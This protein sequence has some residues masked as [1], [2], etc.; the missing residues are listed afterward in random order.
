[1]NNEIEKYPKIAQVFKQNQINFPETLL[2]DKFQHI[3]QKIEQL[4]GSKEAINYLD[5]L[6]LEE[7]GDRQGFPIEIFN[8]ISLIK[9]VHNF[10]YPELDFSPYDPFSTVKLFIPK[11]G[12]PV[13]KEPEA[14]L[15]P[16]NKVE[17]VQARQITETA[18]AKAATEEP[19]KKSDHKSIDWPKVHTQHDLFEYAELRQK[20]NSR[21]YTQQ[22]K[23][24]GEIL[25]HYKAINENSLT[26]AKRIQQK[27]QHQNKAIGNILVE[28]GII[29]KEELTF[30]LCIQSGIIV[31]DILKLPINSE[32][33]KTIPFEI[34][35][36]TH[37]L[38]IGIFHKILYLTVDD[39]FTFNEKSFF[40]MM[41]GYRIELAYAPQ[42]EIINRLN[43][44]GLFGSPINAQ[45]EFSSM[46]KKTLYSRPKSP[47]VKAAVPEEIS[48][49]DSAIINLVN[50]MILNAVEVA[51]SDIH[52]EQFMGNEEADIRFR[53]D[54][55]MEHFAGFPRDH[56]NAV[57]SRIKIIAG[58]D[59]SEKRH[60]Q[61]GKISFAIHGGRRIDL[62]VATIPVINGVEFVT[63]RILHSGEPMRL[64][65]LGMNERDM[66]VFRE[67]FSRPY[68]LILV[69]GP[70]G[71]GKTT[72]LHSVLKELNTGDNKIWTAEDPVEIVQPHL[73]QVQVNSK[74]DLTFANV[75]RSFLRADP[76]II[77][78][79]EMRDHE[80]AKIALEASMT[81][82]LVLST[83]HTNSASEAVARL[84]DMDIDPF[85]LSD[86][87]LA[88]LAQRL[89]RKLC[90]EC[91][92]QEEI[93]ESELNDLA[94]EYHKSAYAKPAT[95]AEREAIINQWRKK[96]G[97]DGQLYS[98][99]PVGCKMCDAGYK[100]RVG[101]YELLHVTPDI[102]HAMREHTA[103]HEY[104]QLAIKDGMRTLKQDGI[105]K[106]LEGL[107]D[108]V[109]VRSACI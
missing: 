40:S 9:Q 80:T 4:W 31:V 77:M 28:T 64:S 66:K 99:H 51:A 30:A 43:A 108:M 69:C 33:L 2:S 19:A 47:V 53:K 100:G 84:L 10:L 56:Y 65:E 68:G 98:K 85:N 79:G 63:I 11:R 97:R 39:P 106:V 46:A 96:F 61:D 95:A 24:L 78:I 74:I 29:T 41:T 15:A 107:T 12:M 44:H 89:A 45:E 23:P 14:P 60:P 86:A 71:S 16:T 102:R 50:K 13:T 26:L 105:E 92:K 1:M 103:A 83:L 94:S 81:G 76:D 20:G 36:S 6:C 75:L 34:A 3:L 21:I 5:S 55:R 93:P 52:I 70:T 7:R 25:L 48:E 49:N 57:I 17:Q 54:G 8:D 35:F 109:H 62:R 90:T 18:S 91:A 101:L 58:L 22:G 104:L 32:T 88:I 59:I 27:P 37:V 38:P 73:C 72:T 82:H 67:I 42:H 87:L